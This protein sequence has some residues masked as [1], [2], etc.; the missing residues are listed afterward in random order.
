ME[1]FREKGYYDVPS[2]S[3]NLECNGG[4]N[5]GSYDPMRYMQKQREMAAKSKSQLKKEKYN[6]SRY[7]GN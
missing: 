3:I 7:A 1:G 2:D 5:D 4:M 6:E